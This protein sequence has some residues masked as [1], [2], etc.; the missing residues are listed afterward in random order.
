MCRTP[1]RSSSSS[2]LEPLPPPRAL[3]RAPSYV[4]PVL[5]DS[6]TSRSTILNADGVIARAPRAR[7]GGSSV[8]LGG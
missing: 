6:A 4:A 5:G 2:L 8:I 3:A 7:L 1:T